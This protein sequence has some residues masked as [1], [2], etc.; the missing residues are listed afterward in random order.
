MSSRIRNHIRSNVVGYIALFLVLTG[1]T[2]QALNGS[3]TVFSDDI[4]NRDVKTA[5]L[6]IGAV[7][8]N[9][10]AP[11]AVKTGRVADGT[12]TGTD[13][14]NGSIAGVDVGSD[15]TGANVA[16]NSLSGADVDESS[17][18]TVPSAD[19]AAT[20]DSATNANTLDG[21]DSS[22]FA[23]NRVYERQMSTNGSA[24][25]S[26]TCPSGD[27][28]YAGGYYCDTG[29]TL[30]GGGFGDIDNGTR[31]VASEPFTPNEQDAWRVII[32]N[33]AT[34]DTITVDTICADS[35]PLHP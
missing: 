3:N 31:L 25:A 4:V 32:V 2:A 14:A 18:G 19:H 26:G 9:R 27:L 15:L 30:L 35:P 7:T 11:N 33:N 6:G 24:N 12:L 13:V 34:E 5:D 10:L 1:G 21:I 16:D 22:G 20:A 17:L 8:T 28:C 29:D 23:A